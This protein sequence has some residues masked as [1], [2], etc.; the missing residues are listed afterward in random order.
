MRKSFFFFLQKILLVTCGFIEIIIKK[1]F[2]KGK[3]YNKFI[4][5]HQFNKC[6][7]HFYQ[8]ILQQNAPIVIHTVYLSSIEHTTTLSKKVTTENVIKIRETCIL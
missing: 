7:E 2:L 4:S 5:G 3:L 1:L 6:V 8:I